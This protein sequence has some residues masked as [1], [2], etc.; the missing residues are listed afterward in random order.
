MNTES[1]DDEEV[2]IPTL[3]N[4]ITPGAAPPPEA[5]IAAVQ[6]ELTARS[7]KL[8]EE[9]LHNAARE[10]EALLF[11]RVCDQL[12]ARLPE[13]IDETLRARLTRLK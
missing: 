10:M 11:E 7:L 12:R 9:L 1:P 2:V 13:L 6:A 8:A 5:T 3:T 4:V